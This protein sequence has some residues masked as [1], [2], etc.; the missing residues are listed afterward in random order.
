VPSPTADGSPS[1]KGFISRCVD[2]FSD[3]PTRRALG[4]GCGLMVIQQCSTFHVVLEM[5][6]NF[7][8]YAAVACMGYTWLYYNLPETKG[9]SLEEIERL[10][11]RRRDSDG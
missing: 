4:L 6:M 10:F 3:A 8:L 1:P 7:W 2:M 5:W 9:L 11:Q